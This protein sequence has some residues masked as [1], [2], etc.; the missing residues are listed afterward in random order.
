MPNS[1]F[2]QRGEVEKVKTKRNP[3]LDPTFK[4][5][6]PQKKNFKKGPI[7]VKALVFTVV[8]ALS[9]NPGLTRLYSGRIEG[10][11]GWAYALCTVAALDAL[12]DAWFYFTHRLLHSRALYRG[13]HSLHHESTVPSAFTGYAFHPLEG[14][15]V[16]AN[17]I[18]VTFLFPIHSGLHRCYHLWTTVIHNGGHAGYEIAPFIPS[19]AAAVASV[20]EGAAAVMGRVAALSPSSSKG[21]PSSSSEAAARA[22]G[23]ASKRARA[24]LNT[25]R[26]HDMHHRFPFAHFSLY[27]THWDRLLGTEHAGYRA[28]VE[29][30]FALKTAAAAEVGKQDAEAKTTAREAAFVAASASASETEGPSSTAST[31]K[32]GLERLASAMEEYALLSQR[33]QRR[34]QQQQRNGRK[35]VQSSGDGAKSSPAASAA[36]ARRPRSPG[37]GAWRPTGSTEETEIS[38]QQQQQ[39]Q[40]RSSRLARAV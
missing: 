4:T 20:V 25:V 2:D 13:V 39:Q 14:A 6:P 18:L 29:A 38:Q 23:E 24:A 28:A 33:K 8:E 22:A 7:A 26:H 40:R 5:T 21:G 30:H 31:T 37:I 10:V 27:F 35:G 32:G 17:E 16:F 36:A 1:F 3:D 34:R 12:H 9:R 19:L 11:T 15:L